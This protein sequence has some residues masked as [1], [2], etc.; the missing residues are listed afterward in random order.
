MLSHEGVSEGRRGTRASAQVMRAGKVRM[1]RMVARMIRVS[2]VRMIR[3]TV[4]MIRL[5]RAAS[6]VFGHVSRIVRVV[7]RIVRA[8]SGSSGWV[9]G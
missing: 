7:V 9:S 1:I 4:R 6:G 5:R 3:V 8:R 2:G